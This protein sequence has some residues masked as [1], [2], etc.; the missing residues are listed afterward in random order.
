M[1]FNYLLKE[2]EGEAIYCRNGLFIV[3]DMLKYLRVQYKQTVNEVNVLWS[4]Y[5]FL[6]PLSHHLVNYLFNTIRTFFKKEN[7]K[8]V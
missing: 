7:E 4:F 2:L 6:K 8:T 1:S 3:K 5:N